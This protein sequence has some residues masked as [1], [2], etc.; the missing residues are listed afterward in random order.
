MKR[1]QFS[2]PARNLE[3][4]KAACSW[5]VE[6]ICVP[7]VSIGD[8]KKGFSLEELAEGISYAHAN[9]RKVI[10]EM[11]MLAHN[12]DVQAVR[13]SME[14]WKSLGIDAWI[15]ADPG[16]FLCAREIAPEIK[17][18]VSVL[19]NTGNYQACCQWYELG[20][21]R[22]ALSGELTIEELQEIRRNVPED[23]ELE[24]LGY[25]DLCISRS[26]RPLLSSF[27]TKEEGTRP[28][29]GRRYFLEEETRK[30]EYMPVEEN[31]RGTYIYTARQVC[32]IK[33]LA[34]LMEAGVSCIRVGKGTESTDDLRNAADSFQQAREKYEGCLA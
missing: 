21:R 22:V 13:K 17:C 27:L 1:L 26:G 20:A 28:D 19:A 34:A 11:D 24:V 6:E 5:G 7:G 32:R 10:L 15:F 4:W 3:E 14:E 31:E 18:C 12:A 25:G 33:E 8:E 30:G 2:V 23:L 29:H 16:L 9:G